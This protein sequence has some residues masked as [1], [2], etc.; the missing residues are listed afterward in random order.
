MDDNQSFRSMINAAGNRAISSFAISGIASTGDNSTNIILSGGEVLQL[1]S[2]V[3]VNQAIAN[4]PRFPA[5]TFIGREDALRRLDDAASTTDANS[6]S[7]HVIYGMGGVG[8]SELAIQ[9]AETH[10]SDYKLI[11]WISADSSQA[12]REGLTALAQ[13][14]YP[15]LSILGNIEQNE[16]WAVGWLQCNSNWLL[17]L[18]NVET[19]LDVKG[20]L[21]Q[22]SGGQ[23]IITTRR[24]VRWPAQTRGIELKVL[25]QS[26]AADLVMSIVEP[27]LVADRALAYDLASELGHL[28]LALDQACAYINQTQ[29]SVSRYL[30]LLSQNPDRAYNSHSEDREPHETIARI[31]NITLQRLKDRSS[32][33]VTVLG[34]LAIYAPTPVPR[35]I[36]M[37]DNDLVDF[38][39]ALGL[40]SSY[41]LIELKD[42]LVSLH[43]L[44]RSVVRLDLDFDEFQRASTIA[45]LWIA[46]TLPGDPETHTAEWP[47]MRSLAPHVR[48]LAEQTDP[49]EDEVIDACIG[50]VLNTYALF[51]RILGNYKNASTLISNAYRFVAAGDAADSEKVIALHNNE[52]AIL[53]EVARRDEA[54]ALLKEASVS[55]DRIYG[56]QSEEALAIRM[57]AASLL[58]SDGRFAEAEAE[59]RK[60]LKVSLG[61]LGEEHPHTRLCRINLA[62]TLNGM[63]LIREAADE[64]RKVSLS[65]SDGLS[66]SSPI[67]V[68][69]R[70]Q[71]V[72]IL[73]SLGELGAA[74]TEIDE[75]VEHLIELFGER[76]PDTLTVRDTRACTIGQLGYVEEAVAELREVLAMRQEVLGKAH[77]DTLTSLSNLAS[78]L[79]RSGQLM[80]AEEKSRSALH[81][82]V[83]VLGEGHFETLTS[84]NNYANLLDRL[85][86]FGE[87]EKE[88]RATIKLRMVALGERH[89]ET[90]KSRNNLAV[91]L[92][93]RGRNTQA[94]RELRSIIEDLVD[95]LGEG[96]PFTLQA[97]TT[98]AVVWTKMHHFDSAVS[99]A[100]K[101][102][103]VQ[104]A[105]LGARHSDTL[106]S[107]RFVEDI[108]A[109]AQLGSGASKS[110]TYGDVSRNATCPCGSGR[111]FK[112]CCAR[113]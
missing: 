75:L 46:H 35:A 68:Y 91:I 1:P 24:K 14:I 18:D 99:E 90:L 8:K 59:L 111:K 17:I 43:Q 82:S 45:F 69:G 105:T 48:C 80:E 88:I 22:L 101:V 64:I 20:L 92:A 109:N 66:N 26:D 97:R 9:Y 79:A 60:V 49:S 4:L 47:L 81:L 108:I 6:L 100:R 95:I 112:R 94:A 74:K 70:K 29:I 2:G 61:T 110:V 15:P 89:L 87:A 84:R 57:N 103:E 7:C 36:M 50:A 72:K 106:E 27:G 56:L 33:A 44:L 85:G 102:V 104:A 62:A 42:D 31:W 23:I 25:V 32:W 21:G 40:L 73:H 77:P 52:A 86:R 63:G 51:E 39:E 54:I 11:W 58:S 83:S 5:S 98:L 12:I 37:H 34:V 53:W 41:S 28:P 55:A 65:S 67:A 3:V 13:R 107:V 38:D 10:R 71:L 19:P 76:H 16:E 96:H 113:A 30:Q 78:Y 93:H